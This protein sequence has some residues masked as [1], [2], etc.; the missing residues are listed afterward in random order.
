MLEKSS[1][2]CY[3]SLLVW[4]LLASANA[5]SKA[6]GSFKAGLPPTSSHNYEEKA[7]CLIKAAASLASPEATAWEIELSRINRNSTSSGA[8]KAIAS[9]AALADDS[10][11]IDMHSV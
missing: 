10:V 11:I 8:E 3:L 6:C 9:L 4:A 1:K 7:E 5:S 2:I